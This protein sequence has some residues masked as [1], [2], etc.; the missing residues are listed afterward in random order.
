MR[1][2]AAFALLIVAP[3]L[4]A[5]A[6][7]DQARREAEAKAKLE[8][9]RGEIA[10]LSKVH[11]ELSAQRAEGVAALREIDTQVSAG[12][13][14]LRELDAAIAAR[15]AELAARE[16]ERATL[17]ATLGRSRDTLGALLRSAYLVGRGESLKAVLARDRLADSERALA[18]YRYLQRDRLRRVQVLLDELSALLA[19]ERGIA[20]ARAALATEQS[21]EQAQAAQLATDRVRREAVLSDFDA[22]L[23]QGESRLQALSRDEQSLLQLLEALRDIF[24]DIP[25][26]LD[27][28]QSF[29]NLKGRLRRPHAGPVTVAF[30]Q[31]IAPGRTSDGWLLDADAGDEVRAMAPGRVAFADW[32]K[33]YGL[34]LILDHGDGYMSLY[35][36]NESLLKDV[37]DWVAAGDVV[38]TVGASG[39]AAH[40]GLYVEI[41]HQGR[42][43]DP[44]PW[45]AR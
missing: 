19:V 20:Q 41:R 31:A 2:L 7:P 44:R 1:L 24:A 30:G 42:P 18:Y 3:L 10:A 39:G 23:K 8:V 5:Q 36:Q 29:A 14:R 16:A 32:L 17:Q 35:A 27:A 33:G 28:A 22:K 26:Q 6:S 21:N 25:K 43:I 40:A 9:L 38:S 15:N 34:L 4:S 37:G 11:A 13:R 45:I 12:A